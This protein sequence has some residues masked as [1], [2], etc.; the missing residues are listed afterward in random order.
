MLRTLAVS[1]TAG[2]CLVVRLVTA[3]SAEPGA[4]IIDDVLLPKPFARAM[5]LCYWDYDH[6]TRRNCFG[7]RLVLVV[8]SNGKLLI[9]LL[10]AFWQKDP[11]R[12]PKKKK[13]ARGKAKDPGAVPRRRT[14]RKRRPHPKRRLRLP[15][16]VHYRTKNELAQALVWRLVRRGLPVEYVL[17]DNWYAAHGNFRLFER[18]HLKWVPRAKGN[19]RVRFGGVWLSASQVAATVRKANYHYHAKLRARTVF[20]LAA[21]TKTFTGLALLLLVEDGKVNLDDTL[22]KYL[23]QLVPKWRNLTIAQL[24]NMTAGIPKGTTPEI[25]WP[26]EMKLLEQ[27]PLLF[28]P[29]TDA[30][31]SNPS[32]RT[33]GTLIEKVTGQTYMEFLQQRVLT[34]FGMTH[35]RPT[36]YPFAPPMAVPYNLKKDGQPVRLKQYKDPAINFAAGMLASNSLDMER[37]ARGLLARRLLR[38]GGYQSLWFQRAILPSGKSV[39]WAFGW[40][41]N[42]NEKHQRIGMN[43]GLPGVASSILIFPE[44]ELIVIGLANARGPGIHH[45]AQ[46]VA[47]EVLGIKPGHPEADQ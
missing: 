45:I 34:P 31:Y 47:A 5:A 42:M 13:K 29:G 35:T 44:D 24:A 19:Y 1:L 46:L 4:L 40:G 43:G 20:G 27:E 3:L 7:Q 16:G 15:N 28:P 26:E 37:Y 12:T 23:P 9:P 22:G 25:V 38:P 41:N 30:S 33:I 18:L 2:L 8:W 14:R 6:N 10:F 36:N 32:Y 21:V 39:N 11:M 17:F